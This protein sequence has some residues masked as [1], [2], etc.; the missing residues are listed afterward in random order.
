V[1][2]ALA[3]SSDGQQDG[4]GNAAVTVAA[5]GQSETSAE[6]TGGPGPGVGLSAQAGNRPNSSSGIPAGL[7][8]NLDDQ[9]V[10][11]PA[12][13][14]GNAPALA[15]VQVASRAETNSSQTATG[16]DKGSVATAENPPATASQ[17]NGGGAVAGPVARAGGQRGG[18]SVSPADP[19]SPSGIGTLNESPPAGSIS[20]GVSPRIFIVLSPDSQVADDESAPKS[21]HPGS[22]DETGGTSSSVTPLNQGN[23][24]PSSTPGTLAHGSGRGADGGDAGGIG[25][26]T[27]ALADALNR[28]FGRDEDSP[29]EADRL[30]EALPFDPAKLDRAIAQYLDQIDD[31][32]G[33]LAD[34]MRSD[35]VLP[36]LEGAALAAAASIVA[37]RWNR[38]PSDSSSGEEGEEVTP[39]WFFGLGPEES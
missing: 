17:G 9:G 8:S 10:A 28:M 4:S 14:R 22:R 15:G 16:V 39:S 37:R 38:K 23:M 1:A 27:R 21:S 31:L 7:A 6:A 26:L 5:K 30:A 25:G 36:W 11:Q 3:G 18:N 35:R 12:S 20:G 19:V 33:V 13:L 32:G 2:P 34:L 29:L 24:P